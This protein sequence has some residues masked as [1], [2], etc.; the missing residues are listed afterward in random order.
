VPNKSK[1]ILTFFFERGSCRLRSNKAPGRYDMTDENRNKVN[2]AVEAMM[3]FHHHVASYLETLTMS[4]QH[5]ADTVEAPEDVPAEV[6]ASVR[7]DAH[8]TARLLGTAVEVLCSTPILAM[9]VK[10]TVEAVEKQAEEP[11]IRLTSRKVAQA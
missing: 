10:N 4:V 6:A 7:E 1:I 9:V 5:F 11:E 3:K 8:R 2:R